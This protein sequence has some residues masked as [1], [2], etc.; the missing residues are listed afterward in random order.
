MEKCL[1][2]GYR[3][4]PNSLAE[5]ELF[6]LSWVAQFGYC[7]RRCALLGL[8]QLWAE[9]AETASGSSQHA[10]VH[11]ARQERRGENL[12][13]Y[14]TDVFSNVLGVSG[15]CDCIEAY[16]D[17]DGVPLPYAQGTFRL[18]P[19]EYKHGV[20]REEEEYHI[21]LCAQAMCL[22][23]RFS[24]TI[25]EGAIFYINAHRRFPV[26]LTAALREKTVE[27][28]KSIRTMLQTQKLP[29]AQYSAKC[30]KCSMQEMCM[31]KLR[32]SAGEYCGELWRLMEE[33]A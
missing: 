24:C 14:E 27:V 10:R 3:K 5:Q 33:E 29:Q 12:F 11:T 4:M 8:E 32:H 23:E 6:P 15:K 30:K 31:P 16:A 25:P 28:A 22:E 18:Y 17:P 13:L 21:Q 20:V 7:P 19:I 26:A 9:N 2:T 1:G